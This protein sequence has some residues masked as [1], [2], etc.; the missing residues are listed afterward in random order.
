MEIMQKETE[1]KTHYKT[2]QYTVQKGRERKKKKEGI[3][4]NIICV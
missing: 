1:K 4:G 3:V 2:R